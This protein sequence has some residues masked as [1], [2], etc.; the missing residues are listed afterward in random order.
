[1]FRFSHL[2]T[3]F[4]ISAVLLFVF[5]MRLSAVN[6]PPWGEVEDPYSVTLATADFQAGSV[7]DTIRFYGR[8]DRDGSP[9]SGTT[10]IVMRVY[11]STSVA[12]ASDSCYCDSIDC[13]NENIPAMTA[14][15]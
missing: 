11:A 13:E 12:A 9:F 14:G 1:M 5:N 10:D 7:P 4:L 3:N 15:C 8:M 6:V 2:L